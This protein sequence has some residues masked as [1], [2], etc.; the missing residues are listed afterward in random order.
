[1]IFQNLVSPLPSNYCYYFYFIALFMLL[2][3]FLIVLSLV[4]EIFKGKMSTQDILKIL[5]TVI[6]SVLGYIQARLFFQ[7]CKNS[8]H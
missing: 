7:M 6:I 3:V 2:S 1:M 4:L 8:I 5:S